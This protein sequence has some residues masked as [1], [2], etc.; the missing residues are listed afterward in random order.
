MGQVLWE[1]G[2][3]DPSKAYGDYT[4]EGKKD[5][6]G[7][8]MKETSIRH[9]M[10]LPYDFSHEE[11]LL[12]YMGR[13]MGVVVDQSPKCH[14]EIAGEG[15]EY[16]WGNAKNKYR[17]LP[18]Q[19]KRG[20]ATFRSTVQQCLSREQLTTVFVRKASK[21]AREYM[22]AYQAIKDGFSL[23]DKNTTTDVLPAVVDQEEERMATPIKLEG[24]RKAV[25]A[26]R[27]AFNFDRKFIVA[28][29]TA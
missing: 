9:L 7:N 10:S 6:K 14:C 16:L 21:Q 23:E 1:S 13:Q 19:D 15:I 4:M 22:V 29:S 12:Q 28:E 18:I 24:I 2:Y 20:K 8:I 5:E 3:I 26:H 11:T 17:K 27:C 25:K